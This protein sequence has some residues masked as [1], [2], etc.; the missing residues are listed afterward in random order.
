MKHE[1]HSCLAPTGSAPADTNRIK[2]GLTRVREKPFRLCLEYLVHHQRIHKSFSRV[3][4]SSWE[5]DL[6]RM[7]QSVQEESSR[8]PPQLFEFGGRIPSAA[9]FGTPNGWKDIS[10]IRDLGRMPLPGQH[11][12]GYFF[13]SGVRSPLDRVIPGGLTSIFR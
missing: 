4:K 13:N 2:P 7:C 11:S 5:H 8:Y 1:P 10:R 6:G 9:G 3:K 12:F